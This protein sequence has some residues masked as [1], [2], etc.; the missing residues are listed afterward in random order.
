MSSRLFSPLIANTSTCNAVLEKTHNDQKTA[1]NAEET[2][3]T[4][5]KCVSY[6]WNGYDTKNQKNQKNMDNPLT[7]FY[8]KSEIPCNDV[9]KKADNTNIINEPTFISQAG[10]TFPTD[11]KNFDVFLN[12]ETSDYYQKNVLDN[13]NYTDESSKWKKIGTFVSPNK[14]M[15]GKTISWGSAKPTNL[16]DNE[17][18]VLITWQS[19]NSQLFTL[20]DHTGD[21]TNGIVFPSP[22]ITPNVPTNINASGFKITLHA[23]WMLWIGIALTVVGFFGTIVTFSTSPEKDK[24]NK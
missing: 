23:T 10:T 9:M 13:M 12:S 1:E 19:N 24:Q 8:S 20:Y 3:N 17:Y 11:T 22:G 2:C 16:S 6:D 18:F 7:T 21:I 4:D 5:D 14:F 15:S